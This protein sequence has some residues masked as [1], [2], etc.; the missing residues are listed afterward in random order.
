MA[1]VVGD[2]TNNGGKRNK[3][4]IDDGKHRSNYEWRV[5]LMTTKPRGQTAI[6]LFSSIVNA[7]NDR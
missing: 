1:I 5:L 3:S 4:V 2:N 7:A 6:E